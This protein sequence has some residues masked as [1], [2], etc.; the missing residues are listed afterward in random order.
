MSLAALAQSVTSYFER[1][2]REVFEGDPASNPNLTVEVLGA[3]YAMDTP[4]ML[5]ITPWTV[6]G[7]A[8]PPDGHLP[9]GLRIDHRHYPVIANEVDTIG[10][11]HSVLLIPDVSD[12]RDQAPARDDALALLPGLRKAIE[13]CRNEKVGVADMERRA[14]VRN[15]TG[16]ADPVTPASPFGDP[17]ESSMSAPGH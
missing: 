16:H 10:R 14:L 12:Y 17:D 6:M 2:A 5:V 3:T 4:V 1:V 9:A 8:F 7:M 13:R 15:L 11:Y